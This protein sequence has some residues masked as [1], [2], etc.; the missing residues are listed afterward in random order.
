MELAL[1]IQKRLGERPRLWLISK[2]LKMTQWVSQIRLLDGAYPNFN[3]STI[4]SCSN[5]D[6]VLKFSYML[7]SKE[8]E[9][10]GLKS[11]IVNS[12]YGRKIVKPDNIFVR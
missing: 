12:L 6:T 4:S 11:K 1:T 9:L 7:K 8:Y 2:I 5:L 3:D 10:K